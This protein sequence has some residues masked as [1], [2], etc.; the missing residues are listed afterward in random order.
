M[1][2][3]TSLEEGAAAAGK[4]SGVN[5]AFRARQNCFCDSS[6][7]TAIARGRYFVR[8][9]SFRSTSPS[10]VRARERLRR[11]MIA[12]EAPDGRAPGLRG[13]PPSRRDE[14]AYCRYVTD[15]QRSQPG[16][17]DARAIDLAIRGD[18]CRDRLG[19]V[20]LSAQCIS[21]SKRPLLRFVAESARRAK[22][23]LCL[24]SIF[25]STRTLVGNVRANRRGGASASRI[26][27]ESY[28][29]PCGFPRP[30]TQTPASQYRKTVTNA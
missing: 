12:V 2:E 9:V 17:A 26:R 28:A 5:M 14:G 1:F 18:E 16:C 22:R 15:E 8:T 10:S 20:T 29:P 27:Y 6:R 23:V 7:S 3:F 4:A 30:L 25:R 13:A 24:R 19:H 21:P 11:S